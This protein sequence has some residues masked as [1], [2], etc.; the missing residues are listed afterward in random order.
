MEYAVDAV[1][2][3]EV[4]LPLQPVAE[5]IEVSR[6]LPKFSKEIED[7]AVRVAFAEDRDEPKDPG[8][9]AVALAIGL[10][11]SFAGEL[12]G[13]VKGGLNREGRVLGCR[14][15]AGFAI[16]RAGRGKRDPPHVLGAHCLEKIVRRNSVLLEISAGMLEAETNVG[17]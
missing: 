8:L 16:D 5:H 15:D 6:I 14:D 13:S 17:V 2:N 7:M 12:R 4:G 1:L 11:Q 10:D 9:L 3:V